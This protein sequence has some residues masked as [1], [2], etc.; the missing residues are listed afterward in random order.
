LSVVS[1]K[2]SKRTKE[3][4]ERLKG[5]I[6]WA[7]ETRAFIEGKLEEKKREEILQR[8]ESGL[9]RLRKFRKG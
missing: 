8:A 2:V 1:L 7:E 9:T 6:N 4:M 3:E 5:R